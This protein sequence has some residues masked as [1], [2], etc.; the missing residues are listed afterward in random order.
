MRLAA[1]RLDGR[2]F[3]INER[4]S[5]LRSSIVFSFLALSIVGSVYNNPLYWQ[6]VWLMTVMCQQL[7]RET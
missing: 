4:L 2:L 5:I 1:L 3:F 6:G 7:S